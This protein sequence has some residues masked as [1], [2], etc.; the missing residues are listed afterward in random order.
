M[1]SKSDTALKGHRNVFSVGP[2]NRDSLTRGFTLSATSD[3]NRGEW[4]HA[5]SKFITIE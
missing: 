4:L 5:L 3:E 2:A 1:L